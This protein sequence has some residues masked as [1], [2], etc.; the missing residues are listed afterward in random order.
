MAMTATVEL[1]NC[2]SDGPTE[3]GASSGC[4]TTNGG[5]EEG[6]GSG[7]HVLLL[8]APAPPPCR[9]KVAG[10]LQGR[11]GHVLASHPA[12]SSELGHVEALL[13]L[14]AD[15]APYHLWVCM[16]AR[17]CD[18]VTRWSGMGEVVGGGVNGAISAR[19]VPRL[20]RA[21][22]RQQFPCTHTQAGSTIGCTDDV[23]GYEWA[24]V[25]RQ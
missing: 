6:G 18:C 19:L 15:E 16:C 4:I 13:R 20:R 22:R 9:G 8:R 11:H 12:V 3:T 14:R 25:R 5:R 23:G 1:Q 10:G 21:S 7:A 2:R 17:M 24:R